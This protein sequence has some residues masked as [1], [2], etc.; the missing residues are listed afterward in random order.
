MKPLPTGSVLLT[1]RGTVGAVARIAVPSSFNQSC[2]GFKPGA[3]SESVLY[4]SV[5]Q[6]VEQ[7]RS[8]AHGSVFNTITTKTFDHLTIP[9]FDPAASAQLESELKPLLDSITA[10]IHENV[11]LADLRDTLLPHLMAGRLRVKDAEKQV[12]AVV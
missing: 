4:F 1:A 8:L 2:Y 9:S 7:A 6:A 10:A 12:E 5:L 3:I 11:S